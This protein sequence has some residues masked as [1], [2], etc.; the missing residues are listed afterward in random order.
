M[1]KNQT[2]KKI[3]TVCMLSIVSTS[4]FSQ[5]TVP[6]ME[7]DPDAPADQ[8][9][10]KNISVR[11]ESSTLPNTSANWR[12]IIISFDSLPRWS[13]GIYVYAEILMKSGERMRIVSN[14]A[15][16]LNVK[17]GR[18]NVPFYL[19]P[20]SVERF[21]EPIAIFATVITGEGDGDILETTWLA[22]GVEKEKIPET[23]RSDYM[24]LPGL[25]LHMMQTPWL[26]YDYGK[27]PD[28][29]L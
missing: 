5:S 21:G 18:I 10:A 3:I 16:L 9:T 13:D 6:E 14:S 26:I 27:T 23:W 11:V 4:L 1:K 12:K 15:R 19:S 24:K 25:L 20:L 17:K 7:R 29:A 28:F 8:P 2:M 22:P